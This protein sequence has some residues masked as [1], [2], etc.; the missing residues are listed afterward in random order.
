MVEPNELKIVLPQMKN[1][2]IENIIDTF[3]SFQVYRPTCSAIY[4]AM[5]HGPVLPL[6]RILK[7]KSTKFGKDYPSYPTV[8]LNN[9][10]AIS[11]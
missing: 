8:I 11:G 4:R 1:R 7:K 9:F 3:D 10:L 5:V 6:P 2:E